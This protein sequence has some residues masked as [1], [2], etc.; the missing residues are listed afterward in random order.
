[1]QENQEGQLLLQ[2]MP[3]LLQQLQP[4]LA[5]Q[6]LFHN[7]GVLI[8]Q[9]FEKCLEVACYYAY[10]CTHIQQKFLPATATCYI[11]S[12]QCSVSLPTTGR[13]L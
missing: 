7:P 4:F 2:P 13:R 5:T 10:H 6:Q 8:G 9:V 1:M 12:H 3:P 11:G